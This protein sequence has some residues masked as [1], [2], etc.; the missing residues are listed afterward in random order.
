MAFKRQIKNSCLITQPKKSLW[1]WFSPRVGSTVLCQLLKDTQLAGNPQELFNVE[2]E[3]GISLTTHYSVKDYSELRDKL[4]QIGCSPNGVMSCKD[5]LFSARWNPQIAEV[6]RL[7]QQ[8]DLSFESV[9]GDLFPNCVHVFLTR[10]NKLRQAVSWWKAIKSEIWHLKQG[11]EDHKDLVFYE[12]NYNLDALT[13]LLKECMLR[14]AA[15]QAY[16]EQN[17]IVPLTL[18]YED[19]IQDFQGAVAFILHALGEEGMVTGQAVPE[20]KKTA[21]PKSEIWVERLR[22]DLQSN[23]DKVAY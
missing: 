16:F 1:I 6:A 21:S 9:W 17:Q 3:N 14:E 5:S 18:V 2:T 20:L 13:H 22:N 19:M 15:T 11:E 12:Q 8:D 7:K 4:W 10:R 23:W